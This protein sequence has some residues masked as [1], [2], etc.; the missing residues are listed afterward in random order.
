MAA[1]YLVD[2][3]IYLAYS[4]RS[5]NVNKR[6]LDRK[7]MRVYPSQDYS[8]FKA[9]KN[10]DKKDLK[11]LLRDVRGSELKVGD[12]VQL[13]QGQVAPCDI[14]LLNTSELH[15]NKYICTVDT[16]F[17]SGQVRN[18]KKYALDAVRPFSKLFSNTTH[19]LQGLSRLTGTTEYFPFNDQ[20]EFRGSFKLKSDPKVENLCDKN[21]IRKGSTVHTSHI[22]GIVLY[23]GKT[24]LYY[25]HSAHNMRTKET[26]TLRFIFWCSVTVIIANI[27]LSLAGTMVL[28]IQ[29][30]ENNFLKT[31]DHNILNGSRFFSYVV[32][33]S[34]ILPLFIL[35]MNNLSNL[36][37]AIKLEWKYKSYTLESSNLFSTL[38]KKIPLFPMLSLRNGD[39]HLALNSQSADGQSNVGG[40]EHDLL[41]TSKPLTVMNPSVISTLGDVDSVYFDK[42]GTLAFTN[43]DVQSISTNNKLY[44]SQ[45]TNFKIYGMTNNNKSMRA[46]GGINDTE[47]SFE[48]YNSFMWDNKPETETS[49]EVKVYD[50]FSRRVLPN[51]FQGDNPTGYLLGDGVRKAVESNDKGNAQSLEAGLN[52]NHQAN[53][54]PRKNIEQIINGDPEEQEITHAYD[55]VEFLADTKTDSDLKRILQVFMV[56]HNA[57]R[58]SSEE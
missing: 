10:K 57:K 12:I 4:F 41:E 8:Y 33:C 1:H 19:V 47:M 2:L 37:M 29:S 58:S 56:C 21:L 22:T 38:S 53:L 50:F 20:D 44:V 42:T 30:N 32:L 45:N 11:L 25:R 27:I 54:S 13:T 51:P 26:P 55:E 18:E 9:S 23:S 28:M 17:A 15:K 16:W 24:S 31:L 48:G 40:G 39:S 49:S 36:I 5:H 52:L 34:P 6:F 3:A 7:Y 35:T 43:Y 14:L 46:Q